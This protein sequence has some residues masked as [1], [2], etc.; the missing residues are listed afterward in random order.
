MSYTN[1][2]ARELGHHRGYQAADYAANVAGQ[3]V[4]D[5]TRDEAPAMPDEAWMHYQ[6]GW[7]AG[8][9]AFG[10]TDTDDAP[11]E[12]ATPH[13]YTG[14]EHDDGRVHAISLDS[15]HDGRPLWREEVVCGAATGVSSD[16]GGPA[17]LH[18]RVINCQECVSIL[19]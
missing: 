10:E 6:D 5:P 4:R 9:A 18:R 14:V 3:P 15:L 1:T 8:V 13:G 12:L 19:A 16:E 7:T 11:A 2:E 17:A